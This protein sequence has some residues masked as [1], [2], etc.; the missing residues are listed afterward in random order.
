M[1]ADQNPCAGVAIYLRLDPSQFEVLDQKLDTL[2]GRDEEAM[3]A[4][5]ARAQRIATN[6]SALAAQLDQ[7]K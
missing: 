1:A 6:L 7:L 3:Q 2:I 4:L 5:V